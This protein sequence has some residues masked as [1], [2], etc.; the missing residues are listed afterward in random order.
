MK[1]E[2]TINPAAYKTSNSNVKKPSDCQYELTCAYEA[3]SVISEALIPGKIPSE[4]C[5][6]GRIR[7]DSDGLGN[8]VSY[9]LTLISDRIMDIANDMENF[10]LMENE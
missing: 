10:Q 5:I 7:I 2:T 9:L 8:G 4:M 6:H 3:L 1:T